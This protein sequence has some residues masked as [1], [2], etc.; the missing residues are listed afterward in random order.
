MSVGQVPSEWKSAIVT[1]IFKKGISSDC[2]NYRPVSL[3]CAIQK[4]MERI[5]VDETLTYLCKHNVIIKEQHGFLQCRS[6][7]TNLLETTNDWT[8][9]LKNKHMTTAVYI[10]YS[11]AFDVVPHPKLFYKLSAFVVICLLGLNNC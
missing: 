9:S 6:T 1:P 11:K 10:G 7:V 2:S 4:I 8:I 5:I 3:C